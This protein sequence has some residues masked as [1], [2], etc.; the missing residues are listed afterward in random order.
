MKSKTLI[1]AVLFLTVCGICIFIQP[2]TLTH[3][4]NCGLFLLTPDWFREGVEAALLAPTAVNQQKFLFSL[5][6]GEVTVR[7][8]GIGAC[9]QTDLG[10]VKYHF[11]AVSGHEARVR[12]DGA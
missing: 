5:R 9:L 4:Q 2:Y 7:A 11:E 3:M 8:K 6:N 10:I 12:Q 1:P